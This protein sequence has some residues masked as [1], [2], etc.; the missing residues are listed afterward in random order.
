MEKDTARR[1]RRARRE[2]AYRIAFKDV[3]DGPL[4]KNNFV[5]RDHLTDTFTASKITE[6]PFLGIYRIG[7][8]FLYLF[9]TANALVRAPYSS[10]DISRLALSSLRCTLTKS[11]SNSPASSYSGSS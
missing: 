10:G 1:E 3:R 8:L 4:M 5:T 7:L 6:S 9:F 11:T 2:E